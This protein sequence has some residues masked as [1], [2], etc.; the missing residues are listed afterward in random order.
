R[1]SGLRQRAKLRQSL[2]QKHPSHRIQQRNQSPGPQARHLGLDQLVPRPHRALRRMETHRH[3]EVTEHMPSKPNQVRLTLIAVSFATA[4]AFGRVPQK[5]LIVPGQSVGEL[6]LGQSKEQ[7]RNVLNWKP[8]VDEDYS[9]PA[10]SGCLAREELHWLD[11]GNP[12]FSAGTTVHAG[13]FCISAQRAHLSNRS[14]YASLPD[15][16]WDNRNQFAGKGQAVLSA[17]G[18][19]L[20][21][22]PA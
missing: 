20:A 22:E 11:A 13:V 2:P 6:K 16:R 15:R 3:P 5:S 12:P 17:F 21:R 4:A 10:S 8:N 18:S 14:C 19:L 1:H 9:Y 7:F